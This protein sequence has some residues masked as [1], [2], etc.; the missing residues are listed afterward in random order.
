M[1]E[2]L[3][4]L[5]QE[6]PGRY[7]SGEELSR[8]L[9]CSRTAVW[10]QMQNL[11][12]DGYEF[13]SA[14]RRGYR[15]TGEPSRMSAA[16]LAA[17]LRTK[18]IGRSLKLLEQVGSTQTH[19]HELV[20]QG[21]PEGTL[22][23]AEE[24]TDGRGRMGRHWHSPK[25]KGVWM[26]FVLKPAIPLACTSQLTLLTAVALCR[27]IRR[28]TGVE[29]GIKWPNDLLARGKKFSGILLESGAEDNRLTHVVF[30]IGID[31]NLTEADYPDELKERATSL[32]IESGAAVDRVQLVCRF[33]EQFEELYDLYLREGFGPIRTLW[34]ALS[35]TL[36]RHVRVQT[37][38]GSVDGTAEAL[39]ESGALLV[40][41]REGERVR[42][43]SGDVS[44]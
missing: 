12:K 40:R 28:E 13:D 30:G 32:R 11:R 26:S 5:L 41:T 14:P 3:L 9:G 20:R 21:C 38:T 36:G 24:Q 16:E 17:C 44:L 23:L 2:R 19:I 39:D 1:K 42:V 15:L 18:T 31:A 6:E 43:F 25:G 35:V 4:T 7:W 27:T 37:P 34:E 33:L 29:A 8:L 22:V 10:K